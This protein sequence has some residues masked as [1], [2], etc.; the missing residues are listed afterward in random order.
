MLLWAT[1]G[2]YTSVNTF[3]IFE[4]THPKLYDHFNVTDKRTDS[5]TDDVP[6]H[7]RA[8]HSIAR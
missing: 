6:R 2:E 3:I 8:L 7:Y 1:G 5:Q 4:V